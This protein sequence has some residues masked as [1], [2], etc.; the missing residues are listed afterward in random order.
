MEG[1][2]RFHSQIV[3][4]KTTESSKTFGSQVIDKVFFCHGLAKEVVIQSDVNII[5]GK[6]KKIKWYGFAYTL[7]ASILIWNSGN[8]ALGV[9]MCLLYQEFL[10]T[11][12]KI[13][14][15]SV[16]LCTIIWYTIWDLESTEDTVAGLASVWEL[17][18]LE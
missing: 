9:Y 18:H 2:E 5:M 15:I 14:N 6:V 10:G 1:L 3:L 8:F 16:W 7:H 11:L 12:Q 13:L 4:F 17:V